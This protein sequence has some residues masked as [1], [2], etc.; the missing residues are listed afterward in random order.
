MITSREEDAIWR[1]LVSQVASGDIGSKN[2]NEKQ[3]YLLF[4]SRLSAGWEIFVV[5]YPNCTS[6][7]LECCIK[8]SKNTDTQFPTDINE[9]VFKLSTWKLKILGL[10]RNMKS[11]K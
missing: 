8:V 6:W 3:L 5:I 7:N 2:S 9:S 1:V 10:D 11:Y 4:L